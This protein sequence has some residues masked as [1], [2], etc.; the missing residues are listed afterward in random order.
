MAESKNYGATKTG[1]FLRPR[2][3]VVGS[4][5]IDLGIV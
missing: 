3:P 4:N 5:N 2:G 1:A